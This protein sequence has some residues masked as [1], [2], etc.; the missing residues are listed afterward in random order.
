MISGAK[1]DQNLYQGD[2][3]G[4]LG[5]LS[6][7]HCLENIM[8]S[9]RIVKK[10]ATIS[11]HYRNQTYIQN[12]SHLDGNKPTSFQDYLIHTAPYTQAYPSSVYTLIGIN[13][14]PYQPYPL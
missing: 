13:I 14:F 8:G 4:N 11:V 2:L 10:S 12:Q 1:A 9:S 5:V 7:I 3:S 6:C